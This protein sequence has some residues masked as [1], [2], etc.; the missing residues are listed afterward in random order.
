MQL[1]LQNSVIPYLPL[2]LTYLPLRVV[3]QVNYAARELISSSLK[4]NAISTF[5]ASTA[6]EP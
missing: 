3:P 1:A 2:R 4:K 6:S 5:A